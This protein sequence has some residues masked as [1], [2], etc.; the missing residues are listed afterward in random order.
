MSRNCAACNKPVYPTEELRCLEKIWHKNCFRCQACNKILSVQTFK[1]FGGKPYCSVHYPQMKSCTEVS[2]TP[3][4]QQVA[5]NT[6]NM[7]KVQYHKDYESLKGKQPTVSEPQRSFGQDIAFGQT[8]QTPVKTNQPEPQVGTEHLNDLPPRASWGA[9][10]H[11]QA[12]SAIIATNTNKMA[13]SAYRNNSS[14]YPQQGYGQNLPDYKNGQAAGN[15]ANKAKEGDEDALIYR[16][17]LIVIGG[18]KVTGSGMHFQ[19][20]YNYDAAEGDEVSF[21]EG[22]EILHGEPID[23][24]WMFGTVRRTGQFGL[25][26]SNYVVPIQTTGPRN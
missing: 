26:P 11:T 17:D 5:M 20:V 4:M 3:E 8:L 7:S 9:D 18:M 21:V 1:S 15:G 24:G 19:A 25:L 2:N 23:E 10:N 14:S 13:D 6:I 22:D 16:P 12:Q